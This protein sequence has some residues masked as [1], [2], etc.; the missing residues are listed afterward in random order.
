MTTT[1][2]IVG[3]AGRRGDAYRLTAAHFTSMVSAAQC[4]IGQVLALSPS[5][6]HLV[7]GGSSYADH[8]AVVL[9]MQSVMEQAQ[10]EG[11][12]GEAEAYAGLTLHLPAPFHTATTSSTSATSPR[13][14]HTCGCAASVSYLHPHFLDNGSSCWKTNPGRVLNEY[15]TQFSAVMSRAGAR[16]S[17]F[18][19]LCTAIALGA[20]VHVVDTQTA[21]K[22]AGSQSL[23]AQR[24]E[25]G[26]AFHKRNS[27][28][29]RS[30]NLIAFTF[31]GALSASST[32]EATPGALSAL[33]SSPSN[34]PCPGGTADTWRKCRGN[35]VHV[36][37]EH[38]FT[39]QLTRCLR[40]PAS[41]H[42][43]PS[44]QQ[45]VSAVALNDRTARPT[46]AFSAPNS[47]SMTRTTTPLHF[48]MG[49]TYR[50]DN[51]LTA[52][53]SNSVRYCAQHSSHCRAI[54]GCCFRLGQQWCAPEIND[55]VVNSVYSN[56]CLCCCSSRS[57]NPLSERCSSLF[58][59]QLPEVV[60]DR[61]SFRRSR[62]S[63]AVKHMPT[64]GRWRSCSSGRPAAR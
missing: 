34:Q 1:V 61:T 51:T 19:D 13:L 63:G 53:T 38:L 29:A 47:S 11:T 43:P 18:H 2:A 21:A 28:V 35:K 8:V 48:V 30:Q 52:Q 22:H 54:L 33:L 12:A 25:A 50:A 36:P 17:S 62:A 56:K 5:H 59:I 15:H 26:D 42:M 41:A 55:K 20:E 58:V 24:G 9:Y 31:G 39:P 37:L 40:C 7:S 44:S 57:V 45:A 32:S 16:F 23:S 6:V 14:L 27:V 46:P 10:E 3:T 4:L 60:S 64:Y 49:V